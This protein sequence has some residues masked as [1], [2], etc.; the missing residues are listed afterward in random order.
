MTTTDNK[1]YGALP[2]FSGSGDDPA[3]A[4][5]P[6]GGVGGRPGPGNTSI[7][8]PSLAQLTPIVIAAAYIPAFAACYSL[9]KLAAIAVIGLLLA[10]HR[11]PGHRVEDRFGLAYLA[12]IAFGAVIGVDARLSAIGLHGTYGTGLLEALVLV[13]LWLYLRREDFADLRTGVRWSAAFVALLALAQR[14]GIEALTPFPLANGY[15][16][17]SALGNPVYSGAWL[18]MS[19]VFARRPIERA[20]ILAGLWAT[21][22]R[23]AW[24]AAL[25]AE[26]YRIWPE[27][28]SRSKLWLFGAAAA[29][30]AFALHIRPLSDI[31]RLVVWKCVAQAAPMKPW[32]GWGTGSFVAVAEICRDAEWAEAFGITTQDHAHNLLLEALISNGLIGVIAT[33]GLCLALWMARRQTVRAAVLAAGVV[34]LLNPLALPLKALLVALAASAIPSQSPKSHTFERLSLGLAAFCFV[35]VGWIV[36]LDRMIMRYGKVPF[37]K[38]PVFAALD[39]G[40]LRVVPAEKKTLR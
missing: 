25:A 26:T 35:A 20:T 31:G 10:L 14:G 23:G 38:A 8:P 32:L 1:D 27:L 24:V 12:V 11:R 30:L 40:L 28:S 37:L 34:S 36:H 6:P 2:V 19:L 4:K 7:R 21:G 15:R 39:A 16:A 18:A 22:S 9:A 5:A 29:L 3:A 13:P 33:M 17:D